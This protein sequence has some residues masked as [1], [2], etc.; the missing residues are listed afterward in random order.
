MDAVVLPLAVMENSISVEELRSL[1]EQGKPVAIVDVRTEADRSDWW[2]AGSRHID[3]Y[4]ALRQGA[5]GSWAAPSSR[6]RR[7]WSL[8]AESERLRHWPRSTY[9]RED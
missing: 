4:A 1:L 6:P 8:C 2:I 7:R 5:L 9:G 3:A